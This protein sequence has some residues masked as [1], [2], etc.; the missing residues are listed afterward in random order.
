MRTPEPDVAPKPDGRALGLRVSGE[1]W[2]TPWASGA[3]AAEVLQLC[4]HI[5]N[6]KEARQG[7]GLEITHARSTTLALPH[8]QRRWGGGAKI[9]KC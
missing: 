1:I 3:T 8:D 9:A 4:D 5:K 6:I 2:E 7:N